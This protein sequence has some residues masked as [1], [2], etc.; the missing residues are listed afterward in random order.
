MRGYGYEKGF[1]YRRQV[2]LPL[3]YGLSEEINY[4]IKMI[5]NFMGK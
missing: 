4:V 1:D 3:Y 2:T 5:K